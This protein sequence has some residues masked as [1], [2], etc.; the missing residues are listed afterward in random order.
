[1]LQENLRQLC[2]FQLAKD[3]GKP[4]MWWDYVTKFGDE[5]T[6]VG[7]T[8]DED[9]AEKVRAQCFAKCPFPCQF[10]RLSDQLCQSLDR[11]SDHFAKHWVSENAVQT[12]ARL[13]TSDPLTPSGS[14]ARPPRCGSVARRR[15]AIS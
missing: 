5:C 13:C 3:G 9:C 14:S 11:L 12:R 15:G 4:W 1:M 10:D 8:Y 7:K 6:M 2:V